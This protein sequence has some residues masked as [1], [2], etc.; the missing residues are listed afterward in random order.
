MVSFSEI[1]NYYSRKDVQKAILEIAKNRE[2]VGVY[3][4]GSFD[5]RPN[6]IAFEDDIIQM[7]KK[8]VVAFHCSL[9]RWSN[10]MRLGNDMT[11]SQINELRI[12]WDFVIDPDCPSFELSKIGVK[13]IIEFFEEHRLRCYSVKFTGGKGFH[14][15]IPFEAFPKR[16]NN[17]PINELYPELPK[18]IIE[19]MKDSIEDELRGSILDKYSLKEVAEMVGKN[20]EELITENK[21]DPFKAIIIDSGLISSRHL[22]RM[23]YSLHEKN[24]LISLPVDDID[25]FQKEDASINRL[26]QVSS[27]FKLPEKAEAISLVIEAVD[28]AKK[29]EPIIKKEYSEKRRE[30]YFN[31]DQFPPCIKKLLQGGMSDGRKRGLFILITFLR[32]AGWTWEQIETEILEWNNKNKPLPARYINSQL[33][34]FKQ[35]KKDLL[36][37]NCDQQVYKDLGLYCGEEMHKDIKNP[38]NYL[39]KKK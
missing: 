16:L 7:V 9:E 10:P 36:P 14:I 32:N 8:G 19:Y 35:Q 21:F 4:N 26:K 1:L 18:A 5:R 17:K 30:K 24:H 23:P 13:H 37:P 3:G 25:S 34:W 29:I 15:V 27:F 6:V 33:K 11:L 20:Q 22:F 31:K 39:Y 38:L 12:G 28:F 2:V